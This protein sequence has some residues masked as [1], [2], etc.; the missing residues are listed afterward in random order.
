MQKEQWTS[1]DSPCAFSALWNNGVGNKL[2]SCYLPL[3]PAKY[4][5]KSKWDSYLFLLRPVYAVAQYKPKTTFWFY[6][7]LDQDM[8]FGKILKRGTKVCFWISRHILTSRL[9]QITWH[10]NYPFP[11]YYIPAP[12]FCGSCYREV[13]RI[14]WWFCEI[15]NLQHTNPVHNLLIRV[16]KA[17]ALKY[18]KRRKGT[19]KPATK[20]PAAQRKPGETLI[21]YE[22][23]PR[24]LVAKEMDK[25][26]VL[27]C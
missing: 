26:E 5:M 18:G 21:L 6:Q 8:W 16:R 15:A 25:A 9:L 23:R 13:L 20:V 24:D 4:A 11:I 10:S 3:L 1:S 17:K 12:N 27:Y 2:L 7:M 19:R 22:K 14:H